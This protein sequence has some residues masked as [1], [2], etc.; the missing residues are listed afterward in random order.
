MSI[1]L[2]D[3]DPTYSGTRYTQQNWELDHAYIAPERNAKRFVSVTFSGSNHFTHYV[4]DVEEGLNW[5]YKMIRRISVANVTLFPFPD[6]LPDG[7]LFKFSNHQDKTL[8]IALNAIKTIQLSNNNVTIITHGH[9][10][11]DANF[12]DSAQAESWVNMLAPNHMPLPA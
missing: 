3:T 10:R 7:S 6:C 1:F 4:R 2:T 11:L 9:G 8:I 12:I 5:I